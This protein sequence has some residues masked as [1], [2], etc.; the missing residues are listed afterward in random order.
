MSLGCSCAKEGW[1]DP[2]GESNRQQ[3]NP[4]LSFFNERPQTS[5][6]ILCLVVCRKLYCFRN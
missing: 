2:N 6:M 1:I 3:N 5:C 4:A